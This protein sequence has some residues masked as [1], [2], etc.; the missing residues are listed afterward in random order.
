MRGFR[1]K[2]LRLKMV[3]PV[4]AI[5]GAVIAATVFALSTL[6]MSLLGREADRALAAS[7][8]SAA[9]AVHQWDQSVH[10]AL[11]YL[12]KQPAIL[13]MD[14]ERQQEALAAT[15][16][17][18]GESS[19]IHIVG[20]DG[21]E[22]GRSGEDPTA[23][24]AGESWFKACMNGEDDAHKVVPSTGGAASELV[25]ARPVLDERGRAVGVIA[26]STQLSRLAAEIGLRRNEDAFT[27]LLDENGRT[28]ITP[29]GSACDAYA[30]APKLAAVR[31]MLQDNGGT[32]TFTDTPGRRSRVVGMRL[33]NGWS[34]IAYVPE[35]QLV[36]HRAELMQRAYAAAGLGLA[37][38]AILIWWLASRLLRPIRQLTDAAAQL[39][40]GDWERRV[41]VQRSDELGDLAEAF[42]LMAC[43]LARG[44]RDI[45]QT[46]A[47]RTGELSRSNAELQDAKAR[48]DEANRAKGRFLAHMSHEIRTPMTS[49]LG[50]A[51]M[52]QEPDQSEAD[53][54]EA[55][56]TIGR[57]ARHLSE[58]IDDVL[59]LSKIEAGQM[60]VEAVECDLPELVG[61]VVSMTRAAVEE[62]GLVFNVVCDGPLPRRVR[63]DPLRVRQ[64]LV[65]LIANARRFTDRGGITLRIA[66][67]AANALE[68]SV[69]DTGIGMTAEQL[70]R[71]FRP[72][73]QAEA[74]TSRHFGGTG[75]GLAISKCLSN[76]LGGDIT[77][78]SEPGV[79]SRFTVR[80]A[81]QSLSEP[82]LIDAAFQAAPPPARPQPA[83]AGFVTG[84]VLLVEDGIDNQRLISLH[85]RRAGASVAVAENGRQAIERLSG[86]AFDLVFMDM[87][88]PEM[89]GS[90]AT[91]EIRRRGW[92]L[93][94]V[95]LTAHALAGDRQTCLA[96][97]CDGYLTKPLDKAELHRT[98]RRYLP[99][100]SGEPRPGPIPM[101]SALAEDP[102]LAEV[103]GEFVGA[104]P[105]KVTRM[106]ELL[107]TRDM[108]E[109]CRFAHQL[110]G[111]AGGYGFPRL[112]ARAG[113]LEARLQRNATFDEVADLVAEIALLIRQVDGYPARRDVL[114]RRD[115]A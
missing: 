13:S 32:L 9:R 3:L 15:E 2:S 53:R 7:A 79:G 6:S 112:S 45:E 92:T 72:F 61:Q 94:V 14:P 88:M 38:V 87:E 47:Q 18:A 86:E 43:E 99:A 23:D 54:Q 19:V 4:V 74:S 49:I 110:K 106:F 22:V 69:I 33:S 98:L 67:P 36:S 8:E 56:L 90:A 39:A 91:R 57:N 10:L 102:E 63:T 71:L 82:D 41:P 108:A 85:L 11:T 84:R 97:G 95:A 59:D 35:K 73:K 78:Q 83:A 109:L 48:A 28:L 46:I 104:L 29:D 111:A 64:I 12:A 37:T 55:L 51:D 103:L 5:T 44:R 31:S 66:C 52:L 115:V 65:N 89:D 93:P 107:T 113:D 24:Y 81:A 42:N 27:C 34:V 80:V 75:L 16:Q 70:A 76:L 58:L 114:P 101:T 50:F 60:S 25:V 96:A 26:I 1:R 30:D 62:K 21:K 77:A 105:Q 68:F 17:V 100:R 20:S 40:R